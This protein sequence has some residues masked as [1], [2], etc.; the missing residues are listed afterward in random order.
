MIKKQTPHVVLLVLDT[1]RRDRLT[2]Y[3]YTRLTSPNIDAFAQQATVFENGISPAQWTIPAHTSIFTGEYP[4]T[5]QTLQAHSTLDHSF[6]TL[7]HLLQLNG[8]HTVGFCN[9]PLI[10]ILN[11]GLKRG[12]DTFYNYSGAVPS[13]PRSS[14][15]LPWPLDGLW[16]WYTQLLRKASYPVQNV[17]A[18]SE[19]WFRLFMRPAFV[20]M[21]TW[22]A[23]FKGDT[24]KTVRD[25]HEC[26]SRA[27]TSPTAKPH[28]L[29]INL[30]QTHT[31]Y[32][33]PESYI[34]QFAPYFKENRAVRDF[35]RNYNS[36]AFR[37][38]LPLEERF[39]PME[40][41]VLSDLY[42]AE[43]AYQDHLLGQLLEFLSRQENILTII[44]ADH[45][46]GLGEHSFMGHS[47]VTYQELVH[48]PLVVKFP[49]QT[50]AGQRIGKIVS[51][52]RIFHTILDAAKVHPAESTYRP[53]GE[54]K[55]LSLTR[56]VQGL[57]PEQE[58]VLVEAYPPN[59]F[60]GMMETHV[61]RMI[62]SFH[63]RLNR[64][65]IYD[66]ED[67]YKLVRIAGI[68]DELYDL[69]ADPQEE[70]D[71]A[72]TQPEQVAQLVSKLE[73][74]IAKAVARR[75]ANWTTAP[76][77]N[78]DDDENLRKQLRALGYIE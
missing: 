11:N 18:H 55:G 22:L 57:E 69:Q 4:T 59:T 37:W 77:L 60:L 8:Y 64:W 68:K 48:V 58:T 17:F 39:K 6:D 23:N 26:L 49:D 53:A 38:L 28:F 73:S 66:A 30:M 31:P 51:T 62:E 33:L 29:F 67:R 34:N 46:E 9:N 20:S 78:F 12:F 2:T 40:A 43:V 32:T 75:P 35:V 21:W 52:R 63:C 71:L 65:A 3:G 36:Q 1:H 15:R 19:F 24:A 72:A 56:T 16:E 70:I 74:S 7:A 45:G 61:P 76:A 25:V 14:N 5:H 27:Q 41:R 54:I 47:F 42:D 10:G 13:V 50:A 44:V